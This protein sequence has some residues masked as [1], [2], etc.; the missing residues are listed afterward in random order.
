[1]HRVLGLFFGYGD[2]FHKLGEGHGFH[3]AAVIGPELDRASSRVLPD[4][5]ATGG[6]VGGG[7]VGG[8]RI[9]RNL[10]RPCR[11]CASVLGGDGVAGGVGS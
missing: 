5:K 8:R 9:E 4:G 3:C 6:D 2:L 7:G 10:Q 11:P 1:M